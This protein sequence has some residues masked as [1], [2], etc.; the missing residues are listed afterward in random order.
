MR[1]GLVLGAGGV[2]GASWTIGALSA[3][4]ETTGWDPREAEVIIGTSAG[5]VLSALIGGG[6]GVEQLLNHQRGIVVEGDPRIEYDGDRDSGGALPPRPKLGIGSRSL[7]IRAARHPRRFPPLAVASAIAAHG[8]GRLDPVGSLIDAVVPAGEWVPHPK[9]W[10]IAMDY[11]EGRRVAFGRPGAPRAALH[12]A[13]MASCA[14][15]G[16]YAPVTINGRRYVDGGACSPTSLDL[17]AGAG[18]DEVYVLSPMTSFSYDDP[19]SVVGRLE[20]RFR[21]AVTKRLLREAAKVRHTG[22]KVVMLGPGADDLRAIGVN[23]M[24]PSRRDAVLDT[25]LHTSRVALE[26]ALRGPGGGFAAAG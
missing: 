6:V 17:L 1:R 13:V 26:D 5:S 18:L 19:E 11:A 7:L 12:D 14:I 9:T 4:E 16:W 2:L 8:R 10:I 25:S 20:R 22:T 21:R 23:L 15:P 3:L 24:D